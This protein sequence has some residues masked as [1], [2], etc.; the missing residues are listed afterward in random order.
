VFFRVLATL[1]GDFK[2]VSRRNAPS[3]QPQQRRL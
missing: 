3:P 2:E 1:D